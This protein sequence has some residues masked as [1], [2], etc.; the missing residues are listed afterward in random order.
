MTAV[1]IAVIASIASRTRS[2]RSWPGVARWLRKNSAEAAT[3]MAALIMPEARP[4]SDAAKATMQ[5]DSGAGSGMAK[6]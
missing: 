4:L 1:P 2:V 5:T 3:A 6:K